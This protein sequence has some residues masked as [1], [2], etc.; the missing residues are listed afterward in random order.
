MTTRQNQIMITMATLMFGAAAYAQE[1]NSPTTSQPATT[2]TPPAEI[3]K[4]RADLKQAVMKRD[5]DRKE[6][7]EKREVRNQGMKS[8]KEDLA[9][10]K[11]DKKSHNSAAVEEDKKKLEEARSREKAAQ[12]EVDKVK[13]EVKK[14]DSKIQEER[15]ELAKDKKKRKKS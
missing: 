1:T 4:D 3:K 9:K 2:A 6:L 13:E 8:V 14:D 7:H 12:A 15:K 5:E 11:A 10:L